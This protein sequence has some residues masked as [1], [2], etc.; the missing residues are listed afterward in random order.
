MEGTGC[1]A[2]CLQHDECTSAICMRMSAA[3]EQQKDMTSRPS[4][5]TIAGL[6]V[7]RGRLPGATALGYSGTSQDWEPREETASPVPGI[8]GVSVETSLG[9]A[10]K[11][12][13]S[14]S[15]TAT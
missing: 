3:G 8:T 10:E 11:A 7:S 13:P 15:T 12:L 4:R 14:R 5:K 2:A 9:V 6:G 1:G